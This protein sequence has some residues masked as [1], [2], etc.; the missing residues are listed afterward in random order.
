MFYHIPTQQLSWQRQP[1]ST[2]NFFVR[3]SLAVQLSLLHRTWSSSWTL[4]H[5]NYLQI[6]QFIHSS[7]NICLLFPNTTPAFFTSCACSMGFYLSIHMH[8]WSVPLQYYAAV[9]ADSSVPP[10]SSWLHLHIKDSLSYLLESDNMPNV[11]SG[12]TQQPEHLQFFMVFLSPAIKM[13]CHSTFPN[14]KTIS[15][16]PVLSPSQYITT[17]LLHNTTA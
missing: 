3:F 4:F 11:N 7:T 6:T 2:G 14:I 12:G 13:S 17:N 15:Y 16:S 10:Q 5:Q 8:F 1:A 9:S